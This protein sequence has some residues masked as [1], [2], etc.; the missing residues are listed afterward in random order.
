MSFSGRSTCL[1]TVDPLQTACIPARLCFP[2]S[3]LLLLGGLVFAMEK[4]ELGNLSL[5]FELCAIGL[6]SSDMGEK[7]TTVIRK[8]GEATVC[9]HWH[10]V[11]LTWIRLQQNEFSEAEGDVASRKRR[12]IGKIDAVLTVIIIYSVR[13]HEK[14]YT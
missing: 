9:R 1:P 11:S 12:G 4:R 5:F 13:K 14:Y 3:P 2:P 7:M 8:L 10:K 6:V